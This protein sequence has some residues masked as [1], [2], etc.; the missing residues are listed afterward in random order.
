MLR[1][2]ILVSCVLFPAAILQGMTGFGYGLVG[3][4]VL[5]RFMSIPEASALIALPSLAMNMFMFWRLQTHFR[6]EGSVPVLASTVMA[7]PLG[8][9]F[10]A[11]AEVGSLK[12]L[13]AAF[14][15]V[16]ALYNLAPRIAT[17]RWHP[18]FLGVPCGF[19]AGVLN[20]A[21]GTAGPPLIAYF[22]TQGYS[23]FRFTATLQIIFSLA[24]LPRLV[25]L[26]RRGMLEGE[27]LRLGVLS[28]PITILGTVIGLALLKRLSGRGFQILVG[29][30]VFLLGLDYLRG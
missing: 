18:V 8:V 4:G 6:W 21:F 24:N 29:L 13:L 23:R 20:G 10:L 9:Y 27:V 15:M 14:L 30:L 5:G 25:E 22:S 16:A 12:L 19:A 2:A 1:N 11:T 28:I 3:V 17:R 26:V 7:V